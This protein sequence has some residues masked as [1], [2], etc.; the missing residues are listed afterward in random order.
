METQPRT[1]LWRMTDE[2]LMAFVEDELVEWHRRQTA[3]T[4][5][6]ERQPET[7]QVPGEPPPVVHHRGGSRRH[8]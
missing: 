3:R 4:I 7:E 6:I 2:Q 5:L 8:G 1:P